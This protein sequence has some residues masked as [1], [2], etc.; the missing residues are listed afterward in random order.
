MDA[1]PGVQLTMDPDGSGSGSKSGDD[2]KLLKSPGIDSVSL[3]SL[4]GQYDN[5]IPTLFLALIDCS[6]IPA[7][8]TVSLFYIVHSFNYVK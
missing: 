6:K 7:R 2:F 8:I 1:D 3:C 5:P 4:V